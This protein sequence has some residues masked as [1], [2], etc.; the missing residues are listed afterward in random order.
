[1]SLLRKIIYYIFCFRSR[2]EIT[3]VSAQPISGEVILSPTIVSPTQS[4][5]SPT[6]QS[7][8]I[9]SRKAP[10][11]PPPSSKKQTPPSSPSLP[12]SANEINKEVMKDAVDGVPVAPPRRQ[13]VLDGQSQEKK[14]PP[15]RKSHTL[16]PQSREKSPPQRPSGDHK[17]GY[18]TLVVRL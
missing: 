13:K 1:M 7:P 16:P 15:L 14:K 4:H 8:R 5:I 17:P 2:P 9:P 10:T 3:V 18:T 6:T 12:Q 11:R